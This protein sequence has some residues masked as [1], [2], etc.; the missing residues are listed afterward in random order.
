M[1]LEE[2]NNT[3]YRREHMVCV[4]W[5]GHTYVLFVHIVESAFPTWNIIYNGELEP[6]PRLK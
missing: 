2:G 1:I 5:K 6:S 4:E 3:L